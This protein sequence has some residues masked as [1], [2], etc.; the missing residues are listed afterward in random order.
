[1]NNAVP[2]SP[3]LQQ[4]GHPHSYPSLGQ[5]SNPYE[6]Q[7][8]G[9]E[10]N[11][12]ASLKAV[13]ECSSVSFLFYFSVLFFSFPLT[14]SSSPL[15]FSSYFSFSSSFI[16][17][18]SVSVSFSICLS[19]LSFSISLYPSV[20]VSLTHIFGLSTWGPGYC[21]AEPL[22]CFLSAWIKSCL[23]IWGWEGG[24]GTHVGAISRGGGP[25][26][27]FGPVDSPAPSSST[28]YPHESSGNLDTEFRTPG[29]RMPCPV[30]GN[31]HHPHKSPHLW[32]VGKWMLLFQ[33]ASAFQDGT[34]ILEL[35]L[36]S[37]QSARYCIRPFIHPSSFSHMIQSR[38]PNYYPGFQ[39]RRLR[40]EESVGLYHS[41][42]YPPA[43]SL[44]QSCSCV[45]PFPQL[46]HK[47]VWQ[48]PW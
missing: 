47:R 4:M 41:R 28:I 36:S 8:P 42:A 39:I 37:Y 25:G 23:V 27:S 40:L 7:P 20:S 17:S 16:K 38:R 6:Q 9:K 15:F 10:L 30:M 2:T 24:R 5:I 35:V 31:T 13:G 21:E 44:P 33:A 45:S 11:K 32:E 43:T 19:S 12:Y 29:L 34:C 22:S 14:V 48:K 3:L 1:M 18:V 26:D 46:T